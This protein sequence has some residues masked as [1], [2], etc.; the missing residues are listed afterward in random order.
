V[1]EAATTRDLPA[2]LALLERLHLPLAGVDEHLPTMLVAREGEQ[3]V[4]TAA[5][6][7]YAD[8]ALLRSVAVEPERQGRQLGHQ[9]TAA[10]LQLATA[11]GANF[12]FLLTTTAERFFPRF[13]FEPITR[14]EV[15]RS[16]RASVEFQ[17]ACPAS[18]IVM[19]KRLAATV[20]TVLFAC[21]H[22]AGRSQ[23]AA[24]WFNQLSDPMQARAI[25]AGTEPA[26][27]VH[28]E[29]VTAMSEAGLDLSG[30]STS[31]LTT[32]LAQRAQILI[33]MGCG[34][35]CPVVPG[36][37]RE[38]WPLEDP[39]DMPL[40]RVREIRDEI[41]QRVETL[42]ERKGWRQTTGR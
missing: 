33:T 15:P 13:G 12:V 31:R 4:G 16:V 6:E 8:A 10:A 25:A 11:H 37:T 21:V 22:N 42:L 36:L 27:R 41:R 24:A 7:L 39:K 20:T 5:L 1:I 34:D 35:R 3:I 30:A 38:D 18:A 23:M 28:P 19:R 17:S 26:P 14:D 29:V 2:I 40:A 9:L 32:E